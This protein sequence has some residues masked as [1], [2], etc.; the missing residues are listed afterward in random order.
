MGGAILETAVVHEVVRTLTHAGQEPQVY[1][2]RTATGIEVDLIVDTGPAL[3]PIE[4]KLSATPNRGMAKG[5]E[6]FRKALGGQAV[7]GYVVHPGELKLPLGPDAIAWPF[8]A[9]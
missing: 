7:R 4:V 3:I 5:I 6:I 9:L 8:A 2:W 1:F